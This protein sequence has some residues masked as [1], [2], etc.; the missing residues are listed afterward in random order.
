M[1]VFGTYSNEAQSQKENS[2][3]GSAQDTQFLGYGR[4]LSNRKLAPAELSYDDR[5][6]HREMAID[7]PTA[8]VGTRKE[9]P[10]YPRPLGD[11]QNSATGTPKGSFS[12][13]ASRSHGH[14][15]GFIGGGIPSRRQEEEQLQLERIKYYQDEL[16]KRREMEEKFQREQEFLRTSLRG[17]K[18]L[19][20]LEEKKMT[21]M[22][23]STGFDN[24]TYL[25]DEGTLEIANRSARDTGIGS[26]PIGKLMWT[27]L[28]LVFIIR[29][30]FEGIVYQKCF[31]TGCRRIAG[32][33]ITVRFA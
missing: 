10:R 22:A 16:A 30:S 6:L 33:S 9:T 5:G 29:L 20:E 15:G 8:F 4:D 13:G 24:P 14:K 19:Q 31:C 3:T 7:C 11:I 17:S 25:V 1:S 27:V 12:S 28:N 26:L 2:Q 21:A 32:A 18:K 23:N